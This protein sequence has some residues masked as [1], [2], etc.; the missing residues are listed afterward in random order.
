MTKFK[1]HTETIQLAQLI[2]VMNISQSGGQAKLMIE[3]GE[4]KVNGQ[5]EY[6]KRTKLLRGDKIEIFDQYIEIE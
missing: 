2:K 5:L 1:I 6:R 3:N 4:V